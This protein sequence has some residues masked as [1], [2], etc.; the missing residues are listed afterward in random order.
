MTFATRARAELEQV[1][2]P[3][4]YELG[5]DHEL[6]G[7][8]TCFDNRGRDRTAETKFTWSQGR[9]VWLLAHAATLA[10]RGLLTADADQ[11]TQWAVRG[12]QFLTEHTIR[13][14]GTTRYAV[15]RDGAPI[16]DGSAP[17]RSVYADLFVVMGLAELAGRTGRPTDLAPAR[18]VL[19]RAS[20]DIHAGTAPTPP[21]AVP[22]GRDALGP[23][24]ILLN[25]LLVLAQAE[26]TLGVESS[27]TRQALAAEAAHVMSFRAADG[28]F[29]EMRRTEPRPPDVPETQ[30]D[31][32]RVPG[33]AIEAIWMVLAAGEL[34][35]TDDHR[36]SALESVPALCALAWDPEYEGLL[37]Y[38]DAAGPTR[39]AGA[40]EPT[41]YLDGVLATWDTK[42]WWVHSE[43]CATTAIA[44]RRYASEAARPWFERLWD[45]TLRTFPAGDQGREWIQIRDR[46]GNPKDEVVALPVKDPFHI[47]RNLMQLVELGAELDSA[48]RAPHSAR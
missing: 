7:F 10:E 26:Q 1:I 48:G 27:G 21:Y 22:E 19:D 32:H 20:A 33:H 25:A 8:H 39:P 9:F 3:F 43:A 42:L 46:Q 4:W 13:P 5:I 6:G 44:H 30:V 38:T 35:G 28:T 17:E 23:H 41:P 16:E 2:L 12:A 37:R 34:L 11:L 18:L 36:T 45:Y 14:D 40:A 24:M 47:T 29:V 31:R 15:H